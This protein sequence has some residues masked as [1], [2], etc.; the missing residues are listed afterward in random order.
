MAPY[1]GS[2]LWALILLAIGWALLPILTI[3]LVF[4]FV[5]KQRPQVVSDT[6]PVPHIRPTIEHPT[7]ASG[8]AHAALG[9]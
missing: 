4:V 5:S 1:S 7:A 8:P 3:V 2:I 9:L 6:P